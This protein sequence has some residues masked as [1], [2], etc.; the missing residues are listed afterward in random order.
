MSM[1]FGV[2]ILYFTSLFKS[3][4]NMEDGEKCNINLDFSSADF[5]NIDLRDKNFESCKAEDCNFSDSNLEGVDFSFC[6]MANSHFT[7]TNLKNAMFKFSHLE[8]CDFSKAR[9][10]VDTQFAGADLSYCK[11]PK[12]FQFNTLHHIQE[13]AQS[14]WVHL[15]TLMLFC[16]YSWIAV[17][18]IEDFDLINGGNSIFFPFLEMSLPTIGFFYLTPMVVLVVALSFNFQLILYWNR[19]SKLPTRFPDKSPI[20]LKTF[21]TLIDNL[22]EG[23][24]P[25]FEANKKNVGSR[26]RVCF[27]VVTLFL[28]APGTLLLFWLRY[29][30]LHDFIGSMI[31]VVWFSISV[32]SGFL[33]WRHIKSTSQ[34]KL[35][36]R[37]PIKRL[38]VTFTTMFAVFM[39]LSY[40]VNYGSR[41]PFDGVYL[42]ISL[43]ELSGKSQETVTR[44]RSFSAESTINGFVIDNANLRH[45]NLYYVNFLGS[46]IKGSELHYA[47]LRK[48]SLD[49]ANINESI[50][51][52]ARLS[53]ASIKRV[54]AVRTDFSHALL[55]SSDLSHGVFSQAN[56]R[57]ASMLY[58]KLDEGRFDRSDFSN[59]N[60]DDVKAEKANF[61]MGVLINTSLNKAELDYA[62]F[63]LARLQNSKL[64]KAS[65]NYAK[66]ILS[67]L[68]NAQFTGASLI[69]SDLTQSTLEHAI[70]NRA[71]LEQANLAFAKLNG[72]DFRHASLIGANLLNAELEDADFSFSDLSHVNFEGAW[73][74]QTNLVGADLSHAKNLTQAQLN[75]AITDS[76]TKVPPQFQRL[77]DENTELMI[78]K[79]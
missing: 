28:I 39:G 1:M 73:L 25:F 59:A 30:P 11:F 41:L 46:S 76:T 18:S 13:L 26:L 70:F 58:A 24:F 23:Y 77:I 66:L 8:G 44:R 4:K 15:I 37:V 2:L 68:S 43:M 75:Q 71:V 74:E 54:S 50:F 3:K 33:S 79:G 16:L 56:F 69:D 20:T 14:L 40:H 64:W 35:G 55:Q 19:L 10:V 61:K 49:G 32:V 57:G 42:D 9:N 27:T 65:L 45:A 12:N 21:P 63:Y 47:D 22:I 5:S 31:H 48:S 29:L 52:Y 6:R 78:E 7:N 51:S 60:M 38:V 72:S 36:N 17:G 53:R 67:D 62:N 34:P